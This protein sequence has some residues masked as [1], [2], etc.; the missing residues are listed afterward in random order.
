M[1]GEFAGEGDEAWVMVVNLSLRESAEV[2][3]AW[4]GKVDGSKVRMVSAVNGALVEIKENAVWLAAGQ[5]ML[6]KVRE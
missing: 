6:V 5:G 4:V 2:K 3:V 1:V